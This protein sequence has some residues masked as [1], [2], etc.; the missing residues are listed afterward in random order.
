MSN[1]TKPSADYSAVAATLG[2]K[3]GFQPKDVMARL[4]ELLAAEVRL[5]EQ[6]KALNDAT[7]VLAGKEATIQNLQ[8]SVTDLTASLKVYQDREAQ[9]KTERI[10]AM[11]AKAADK[12]PA[13][14]LPKWRQLAQENPDL[15][16]STLE[17]IPAVEQISRQIASDPAGVQA[18]AA[19]AKSAEEK[20]AEKVSAVVGK[21]FAFRTLG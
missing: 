9:Q 21:D 16:E 5:R 14:D 7:T 15:V 3:E 4:S 8:A 6:E 20:M 10:E 17:S 18:A 19:A 2:L 1:E 12:I 13:D 11:L